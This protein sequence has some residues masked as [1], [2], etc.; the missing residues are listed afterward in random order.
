MKTKDS[1]V[2]I[3]DLVPKLKNIL[4]ELEY[5]YAKFHTDLV[6]T[7]GKD[8]IHGT[9]SLHYEGKAVDLR[10]WNVLAS[11]V[12]QIKAHIGP[13]FDVILEKDHIHIEF[14]TNH[15]RQITK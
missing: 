5:V 2:N 14:D 4:S 9:D 3:E 6:I 11:L 1:S 7:S 10:T 15:D 8:G 13:D 12:E